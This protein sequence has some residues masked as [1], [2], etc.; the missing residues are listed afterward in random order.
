MPRTGSRPPRSRSKVQLR[1]SCVGPAD[2]KAVPAG[3]DRVSVPAVG[4]DP[5]GDVMLVSRELPGGIHV[6]ARPACVGSR[7][8]I[9]T[10]TQILTQMAPG[11]ATRI[12]ASGNAR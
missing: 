5:G 7:G 6:P 1:A 2:D 3:L 11:L 4:G 10:L 8:H 12:G 9:S